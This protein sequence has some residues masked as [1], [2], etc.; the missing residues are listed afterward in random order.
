MEAAQK[1]LLEKIGDAVIAIFK[2][3]EKLIDNICDTI[4]N[5]AIK[6]KTDVQKMEMMLDRHPEFKDEVVCAFN[7]GAMDLSDVKSLKELDKAFDDI[8]Q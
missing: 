4:K 1:S 2:Q 7:K 8:N 5:F 3:F 6:K